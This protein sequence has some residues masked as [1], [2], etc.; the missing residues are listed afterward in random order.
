MIQKIKLHIQKYIFY[1]I[2]AVILFI[3]FNI[4][5][6]KFIHDYKENKD[7][8]N[9]FTSYEISIKEAYNNG[10]LTI[11]FDDNNIGIIKVDDL[12][13][14]TNCNND[15]CDNPIINQ[16]SIRFNKDLDQCVGYIIVEK[17]TN[18]ELSIDTSHICDMIDY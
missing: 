16:M 5:L 7:L 8:K 14:S 2:F 17:L 1:D 18:N 12:I 11:N 9:D 15:I 10:K 4:I 3:L 13:T 6:F